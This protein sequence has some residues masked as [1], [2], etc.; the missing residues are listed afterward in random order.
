MFINKLGVC[1]I[2]LESV[3]NYAFLKKFNRFVVFGIV[4]Y[5]RVVK[6]EIGSEFRI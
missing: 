1:V 6:S 5:N 2:H 3:V 4:F